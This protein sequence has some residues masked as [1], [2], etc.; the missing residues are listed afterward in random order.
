MGSYTLLEPFGRDQGIHATIAYALDEGLITYRDVYN[1]KPPLTTAMHWISQELFGHSMMAIRAL[2]LLV[3]ALTACALVEVGRTLKKGAAFA[4]L[5]PVTFTTIYYSYNFWSHAQTDGWAGF[6]VVFAFWSMLA[7]WRRGAGV[8]RFTLML[9]SGALLGLAFGLKYT[10]GAT[11]GLV[12]APLLARLLGATNVR[13][14]FSDLFANVLG[15]IAVLTAVSG[16]MA[17]AGALAPFLE[18]QSFIRGYVGYVAQTP[19][20]F[21]DEIFLPGQHSQHLEVLIGVMALVALLD[22]SRAHSPLG[23]VAGLIW[24]AAAWLS[25]SIQGKGFAYHYLPLVPAHAF[26]I[27]LGAEALL[28]RIPAGSIR[29]MTILISAA[30]VYLPSIAAQNAVLVASLSQMPDPK[31]SYYSTFR[32]SSDF[33]INGTLAFAETLRARRNPEDKLFVWGYETMLYFLVESPPHYRYVYNWPF[34]VSYY[35]GR[36]TEDLLTRLRADPPAQFVVQKEDATPWVTYREES[37]DQMLHEYPAL[38]AFLR[39]N[40]HLVSSEPK[41]D[42]YEIN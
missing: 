25:G 34:M 3:T 28:A 11:G 42:L 16:T 24:Y 33:D 31:A 6:L 17:L 35:D 29:R 19:P 30:A 27:G 18:I 32:A 2:D 21:L 4:F 5:A 36:Y 26:M 14:H 39:D 10:I 1:I 7:A 8:P 23:V 13:F 15:G 40:Y 12:F 9:L 41:Y 37:S 38:E 20:A 22:A